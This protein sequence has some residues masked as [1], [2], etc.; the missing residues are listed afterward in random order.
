MDDSQPGVPPVCG[1]TE[2]LEP[3]EGFHRLAPQHVVFEQRTGYVAAAIGGCIV[4]LATTPLV[5]LA[6]QVWWGLLLLVSGW[7]L[8]AIVLFVSSHFW[9]VISHRHARWRLVESGMEIHRGVWWKHRIAIPAAR[10][11]HVDVSQGP[12]QRLFGLGKL[13]IH[14][15]G[16]KNASVELDGLEH[17]R[18]MQLR[19]LLIEQKGTRDVT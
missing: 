6:V 11:Q 9:P 17:A 16:T 19:D 1:H 15:A 7:L 4:W 13:T 10:V 8:L 14:T 3:D 2:T 5:W 12:V 18:A